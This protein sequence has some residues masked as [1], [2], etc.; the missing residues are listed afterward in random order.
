MTTE[1]FGSP[2]GT[3]AA[4]ASAHTQAQTE[5]TVAET[6]WR[7]VETQIKQSELDMQNRFASGMANLGQGGQSPVDMA[8]Q[9][10]RMAQIA[11]NA[12]RPGMAADLSG[13]SAELRLH[14]AQFAYEGMQMDFQNL[15]NQ[16]AD[17]QLQGE[18]VAGAENQDSFDAGNRRYKTMTGKE[19]PYVGMVYSPQL[20]KEIQAHAMTAAEND[21]AR[22]RNK[23]QFAYEELLKM[24]EDYMQKR[25]DLAER[26]ETLREDTAANKVKWGNIS[27]PNK[28]DILVATMQ[29]KALYP[30]LPD[31]D[32]YS[33]SVAVARRVKD[34]LAKNPG[35]EASGIKALTTQAIGELNQ[36][37]P[38]GTADKFL[39]ILED[40][41]GGSDKSAGTGTANSPKELPATKA[42]M[43]EG[44]YYQTHKGV[45]QWKNG[46]LVLLPLGA[47]LPPDDPEVN[48]NAEEDSGEGL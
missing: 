10:D 20:M 40:A 43:V 21:T 25:I 5:G 26:A 39:S 37:N 45:A 9:I 31:A 35:M 47:D 12:G 8:D 36:Q 15:K 17:M 6:R 48:D 33:A 3:M 7:N 42:D 14:T 11:A 19:S 23:H 29:L 32:V 38:M 34:L 18:A 2:V 13:K 24:K 41:V 4:L 28:D 27:T 44:H 16:H 46:Q 30:N 1:M 22:I